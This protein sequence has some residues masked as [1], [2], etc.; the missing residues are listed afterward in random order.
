[1]KVSI[2]EMRITV[3]EFE[4]IARFVRY[5]TPLQAMN[6]KHIHDMKL[7]GITSSQIEEEAIDACTAIQE[8][9]WENQKRNSARMREYRKDKT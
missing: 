2:A 5:H 6:C 1:M 3:K 4:A 9:H 7:A 8:R